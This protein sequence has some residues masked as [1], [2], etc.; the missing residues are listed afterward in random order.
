MEP[1][2]VHSANLLFLV[3][4]FAMDL[5]WR[6]FPLKSCRGYNFI[7]GQQEKPVF[8]GQ[9][10][11]VSTKAGYELFEGY[12]YM[13]ASEASLVMYSIDIMYMSRW[14]ITP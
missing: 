14:Y 5:L 8:H 1:W 13:I 7:L 3:I 11:H 6:S 12:I 9:L 2:N 10:L 4:E